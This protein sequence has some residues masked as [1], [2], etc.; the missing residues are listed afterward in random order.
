MKEQQGKN[1]TISIGLY[2][3]VLFGVRSYLYDGGI[4]HVIYLPLIDLCIDIDRG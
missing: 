2:P 3:G 1:W 4:Q